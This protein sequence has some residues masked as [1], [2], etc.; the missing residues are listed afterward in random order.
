M[1]LCLS[2]VNLANVNN[3][4]CTA[5]LYIIQDIKWPSRKQQYCNPANYFNLILQ[6]LTPEHNT[7][8]VER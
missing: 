6:Y 8:I 3:N 5:T 2:Y 4:S 7:R 1:M